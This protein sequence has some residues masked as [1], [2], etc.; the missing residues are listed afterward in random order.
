M[1]I[2]SIKKKIR[3]LK[4]LEIQ[5]RFGCDKYCNQP[6]L[7]SEFFD[8]TGKKNVKYPLSY[9]FTIDNNEYRRIADEF[10]DFVYSK[11]FE[12]LSIQDGYCFDKALLI[13]LDLPYDADITAIKKRFR[14]LAKLYHPDMG[15]DA[16]K[17][18]ELMK[19]Y[20]KL[21]GK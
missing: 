20:N 16:Q 4:K 9:L 3:K 8:L 12:H 14:E 21:I 15:G 19:I 6:L 17:F 11:L 2:I 13:K 18:I 1:D 7:W 5:I 10:L